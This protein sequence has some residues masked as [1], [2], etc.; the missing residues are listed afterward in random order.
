MNLSLKRAPY[1]CGEAPGF[2]DFV[3]IGGFQWLRIV[4]GL[5][6]MENEGLVSE[7]IGRMLNLYGGQGRSVSEVAA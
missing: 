1:V 7:W 3:A 2:A 5:Q 6:M 4:S